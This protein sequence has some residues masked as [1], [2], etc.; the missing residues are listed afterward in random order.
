LIGRKIWPFLTANRA[1][2]DRLNMTNRSAPWL[3]QYLFDA[4]SYLG[5]IR[6]AQRDKLHRQQRAINALRAPARH[7]RCA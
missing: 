7:M 4:R 1:R 3:V 6:R 5:T 2:C